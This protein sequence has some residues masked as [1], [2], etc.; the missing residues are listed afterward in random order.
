MPEGTRLAGKNRLAD[1][2]MNEQNLELVYKL[3]DFCDQRGLRM[4]DVAFAWLLAKP[5]VTSVIAGAVKTEQIDDNV[6]AVGVRLSP[7]DLA[8]LD[9]LT[10][11]ALQSQPH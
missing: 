4:V 10:A 3:G 9:K 8:E 2:F 1:V 6:K 11:G 7:L 5:V